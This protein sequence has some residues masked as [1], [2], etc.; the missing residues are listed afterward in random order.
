MIAS[1]GKATVSDP[2]ERLGI[3]EESQAAL[4]NFSEEELTALLN[5]YALAEYEIEWA[6]Q[7]VIAYLVEQS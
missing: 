6:R 5:G 4:D 3:D 7:G 1:D 2:V